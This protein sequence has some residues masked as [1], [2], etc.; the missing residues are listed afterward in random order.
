MSELFI[1]IKN[2]DHVNV[3]IQPHSCNLVSNNPED[4]FKQ[5]LRFLYERFLEEYNKIDSQIGFTPEIVR[6]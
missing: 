3:N 4:C 6:N 2:D 1:I 5:H